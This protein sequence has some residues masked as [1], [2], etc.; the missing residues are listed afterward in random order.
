MQG[1]VGNIR[2]CYQAAGDLYDIRLTSC[3]DLFHLLRIIEGSDTGN[4]LA[5]ILLDV[6]G[7]IHIDASGEECVRV[8][9]AEHRRIFMVA[10]GYLEQIYLV[11]D[12]L[13]DFH[14]AVHIQAYIREIITGD[15]A[16]NRESG[17][18]CL[19]DSVQRHHQEPCAVLK[20]SAELIRP[21]VLHRREE[22]GEQPSMGC[23]D[24]YH[25]KSALLAELSSCAVGFHDLKDHLLWHLFYMT[26]RKI[27]IADTPCFCLGADGPANA[28]KSAPFSA[29]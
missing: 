16:F 21:L 15:T 24:L 28:G 27:F 4:R 25:V 1:F 2:I 12:Q 26:L 23:M 10:A 5:D 6:G 7:K 13:R 11:L 22:L 20:A 19:A 8:R 14:A 18:D 3:D 9:T 17:A 29:V